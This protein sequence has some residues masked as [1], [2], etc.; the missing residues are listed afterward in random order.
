[1]PTLPDTF[2]RSF[3][4]TVLTAAALT[5]QERV[6]VGDDIYVGPNEE[7]EKAVCVGCSIRI[8]GKV[9]EAVAIGGSIQIAGEVERE[10]VAIG[11]S[12]DVDG[13]VG[14]EAVAIAGWLEINGEVEHEAVS[15]LGGIRLGPGARIGRDAVVVLGPLEGLNQGTVGGDVHQ[16]GSFKPVAISGIVIIVVLLAIFALAIW[17]LVT[18]ATISILGPRRVSVLH[19]TIGRRAGMCLLLGFGTWFAS[20]FLPLALFWLPPAEF[21]VFVAFMVVAAVGYAGVSY[22]V[23]RGLVKSRSI[24]ATGV[25]GAILVTIIQFIPV[26]GWFIATPVFGFLALGAAVLSGFG[27]SVDWMLQR[28]EVEPVPRP[29]PR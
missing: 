26:I 7:I 9:R 13:K 12:I 5:A 18:L 20:I 6:M 2:F 3:A 11:G 17:P 16:G 22:W 29:V 19:E 8:D 25:L 23:G 15:I 28:S 21:I 14:R 4:L 27:T 1:M 10:A 24:A